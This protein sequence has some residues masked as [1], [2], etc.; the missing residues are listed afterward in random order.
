MNQL[1]PFTGPAS[2]AFIEAAGDHA[3]VRFV[4]FFHRQH[5]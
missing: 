5:P 2:L 1:V 4:E 3:R